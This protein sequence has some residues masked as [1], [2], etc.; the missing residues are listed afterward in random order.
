MRIMAFAGLHDSRLVTVRMLYLIFVHLTGWWVLLERSSA[1]KD[2]EVAGAAAGARGAAP[3]AS[4]A[5]AGLGSTG[6]SGRPGPAAA[7]VLR[8]GRLVMPDTLLRWHQ[9]MVRWH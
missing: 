2:A 6:R 4:A 9:R 5:E 1:V 3:P 8:M 7:A